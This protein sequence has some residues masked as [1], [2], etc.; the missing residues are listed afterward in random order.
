MYGY[1]QSF[2]LDSAVACVA[3][4]LKKKPG[5]TQHELAK[6]LYGADKHHLEYYGSL[7]FGET[8]IKMKYGPVPSSVYD[9]VKVAAGQRIP[10]AS[11]ALAESFSAAIRISTDS[12]GKILGLYVKADP[13]W[14]DLSEAMIE[15][16]NMGIEQFGDLG[17]RARTNKSHDA[18]WQVAAMN[19]PMPV[20]S[21][22][23]TLPNSRQLL[24]HLA[25]PYP[26]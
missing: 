18:A 26:G 1:K 5:I 14:D 16:L 17:F 7:M 2:A 4:V 23:E 20:E 10:Q 8:Y 9:G 12:S 3:Y 15:S 13:D 25:D 6:I 24:E 19:S 22:A 11:G 21:I